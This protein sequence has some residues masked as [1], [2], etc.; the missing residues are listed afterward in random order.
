[1]DSRFTLTI[2]RLAFTVLASNPQETIKVLGGWWKARRWDC[3]M[4]VRHGYAS[5]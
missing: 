2:D 4:P 3:S 1:M 5:W